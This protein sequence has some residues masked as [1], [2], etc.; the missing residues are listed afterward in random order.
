MAAAIGGEAVTLEFFKEQMHRMVG[1]RFAPADYDTHWEGLR[2]LPDAVLEAAVGRAVKTRADFPTP[3]ELRQDAD[4]VAGRVR[5]MEPDDD[6][7]R[8]PLVEP[9]EIV[10][11]LGG[12]PIP[13]RETWSYYCETCSDGGFESVWCG[14]IKA[15]SRAP[16][17]YPRTCERRKAHAPHE[18]VRQCACWD[19]NPALIRKRENQRKY[20]EKGGKAA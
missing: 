7:R 1:L 10:Y 5:T 16:W 4:Q 11:P 13:V 2:E 15:P 14:D 3:W 8:T 6:Q 18:W 9:F 17:M 19:T 12:A 20:A